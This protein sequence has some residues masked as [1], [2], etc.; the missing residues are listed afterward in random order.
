MSIPREFIDLLLSK[1]DIVALI[2][3]Q[4]PLRKKSASN[5]FACCPFHQ[6]KTPSFCVNQAKQF[7][8]CFGCGAHGNAID[9]VLQ[10][11][12]LTFVD[13]IE[14]LARFAG[15]EVPKNVG[16]SKPHS[17]LALYDLM[18]QVA[19]LYYEQMS[20]NQ[21]VISYLKNRGI[22]GQTAKAF[23]LGYAPNSFNFLLDKCKAEQ[24]SLLEVG[25]IIRKT[26]GGCYDRFRDRIMFPIQDYR[27][28][29][30]GFG[31]RILQQGEPKYLNS[32]E[33]LLFQK[34]HE[35]Y[36]LNLVLK[37][38]RQLARI[39]V[40]EGYM[41]VIGLYQHGINY[42]VA[43]LGTA[44]SVHHVQRLVRY[45]TEIIFCFD[46]DK[47]GRTAALRA[48][49]VVMPLMQDHWQVKFLFLPEGEDPDSL[50]QKEGKEGFEARILTAMNLSE[51]FLQSM[52]QACDM[53]TLEGRARFASQA[54]E[55]IKHVPPSV[56]QTLLMSE[57]AKRAR[58]ELS[59]LQGQIPT[60]VKEPV[61]KTEA[62]PVRA[63]L[64]RPVKLALTALVQQPALAELV[65][66]S[67]PPCEVTGYKFL[68]E[69][70][71]IIRA[72]QLR[73][74]AALLEYWRDRKERPF[75]VKLLSEEQV[76]PEAGLKNE[77]L[78]AIRQLRLLACE[79]EIRHLEERMQ[80]FGLSEAEKA[81]LQ[82]CI[83]KKQQLN[84]N[85]TEEN[86]NV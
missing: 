72:Q 77:F 67:L 70:I 18:Q 82:A 26:E 64:P 76:V 25:L 17:H 41:D 78:G 75:L 46:G 55:Q 73:S 31:G 71:E 27:G 23:M 83:Q 30:I 1:I 84:K 61:Q 9:F 51:F 38:H 45:T 28:R 56:L 4:L 43:T 34:S 12:R 74:S 42:A 11:E 13:A 16:I 68:L 37:Q 19:H 86:V 60:P 10:Y 85:C 49:Q 79:V 69:M 53:Q 81:H 52:A 62:G 63:S 2:D 5:Y 80:T 32:P 40:V 3:T 54:L 7:F 65:Q 20:K 58:L 15:M 59:Q 6:E 39:L 8:Y 22:T 33:T 21:G 14:T 48:L 66:I 50:V 29:V 24:K 36:G 35:L 44:T 47:A 57:V